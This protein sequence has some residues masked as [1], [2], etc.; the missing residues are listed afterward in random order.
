[1]AILIL[2]ILLRQ[3]SNLLLSY[4]YSSNEQQIIYI[5][6]IKKRLYFISSNASCRDSSVGRA[7]DWRSEGPWFK[8]G[9]LARALNIPGSRQ[10]YFSWTIFW[11]EFLFPEKLV[12]NQLYFE[13]GH[14]IALL[15]WIV[16]IGF[17]RCAGGGRGKGV[18]I[19]R[20]LQK[21]DGRLRNC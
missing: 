3:N 8:S 10:Y 12:L 21:K 20:V 13:R 14:A 6:Y 15:W 19:M 16:N 1:M 18:E 4:T 2:H 11:K 17:G 7:S 9:E 5:S